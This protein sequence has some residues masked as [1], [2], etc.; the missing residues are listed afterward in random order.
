MDY[1][2]SLGVTNDPLN[3][4]YWNNCSSISG[5]PLARLLGVTGADAL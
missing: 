3:C 5:H 2:K 1:R 4:S